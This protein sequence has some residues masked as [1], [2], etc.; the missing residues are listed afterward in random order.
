M[1]LLHTADWH[2]NER[3]GRLPRQPD[4]RARLEEIA[5]YLDRYDVDVMVVA[6]DVFSHHT[7]LEEV[8]DAVGDVNEVFKPFLTRGGT[9]VA[10]S[11]N[12]DNEALFNLLRAALDLAHPLDPRQPGPRPGGRLYLAAQP[13]CLLLQD[14]KGQQVQFAL[15]PYPTTARYLRD[16]STGYNSGDE[17]NHL[18]HGALLQKLREFHARMIDARLPSVLVSHIHVRG[19]EIHTLYRITEREDVIFDPSDIPTH[20]A[21]VAYGHIHRPQQLCGSPHV[22]YAGSIERFDYAERVDEKGV[23]LVEIGPAGRVGEPTLLPLD[24]TPLY[25]IEITDPEAQLPALREQYPDAQRALVAYRLI[26]QPGE[27]NREEMCRELETVFPRCYRSEVVPVGSVLAATRPELHATVRN[28]PATVRGY[29][30]EHLTQD[31]ERDDLLA[32]AEQYLLE[33]EAA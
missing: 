6:G 26:Y 5:G 22:R 18:L 28:V 24:A 33:T 2:L 17:R 7:R 13:T 32:L 20:W 27:H 30:E 4:I 8:R 29:L 3:L 11:G 23:V 16:E 9:I 21:Y 19:S 10:I 25:Q 15:L 1:R 12:H 31:P 14:R